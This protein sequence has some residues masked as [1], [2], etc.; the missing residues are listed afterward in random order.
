MQRRRAAAQGLESS[1]RRHGG[2]EAAYA[3]D[4]R[5]LHGLVRCCVVYLLD[6][7]LAEFAV[8][9]FFVLCKFEFNQWSTNTPLL[10]QPPLAKV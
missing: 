7:M 2:E 1:Y 6:V 5:C 4:V 8:A 9:L 10:C 3:D